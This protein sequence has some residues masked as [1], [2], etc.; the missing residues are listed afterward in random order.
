MRLHALRSYMTASNLDACCCS[1][2]NI[3]GRRLQRVVKMVTK[4]G[5]CIFGK[6]LCWIFLSFF[7]FVIETP[8]IS[9]LTR[10]SMH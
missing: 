4:P 1:Y 6:N 9:I 3:C 10:T 5:D 8:S 7:A 2:L